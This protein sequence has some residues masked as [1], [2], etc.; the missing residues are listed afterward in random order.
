MRKSKRGTQAQQISNAPRSSSSAT[1]LEQCA[2]HG[3]RAHDHR[4]IDLQFAIL[5]VIRRIA[6]SGLSC[7]LHSRT[8]ENPVVTKL[9][10]VAAI[11]GALV[12]LTACSDSTTTSRGSVQVQLTDAPFPFSEV[13]RVD[14]HVL[15]IDA[16][17]ADATEA[18]AA[19]APATAPANENP[20]SGW[21]TI[22]T[23][24]QAFNMLSL[25]NGT[26]VNLGSA[27]SLPV[28]QYRG[29][30][31][32]IDT[33]LSSVTLVNG[34]VLRGTG[35][36]NIVWPSAGKTGIK[37]KLADPIAV[38]SNGGNASIVVIDF[39][40]ARSF[41]LRGSSISQNGLLFKPVIR[42]VA[43]DITGSISGTVR[44]GSATGAVVSG[45]TIEILKS[46]TVLTDTVSANVVATASTDAT[47]A[48]MA[49][50]LPPATYL[51]RASLGDRRVLSPAVTVA[52]SQA[53]T[54]QVLLLP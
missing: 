39:D 22:A 27:T 40:L 30:R 7:A 53:V 23:P 10:R 54:G 6:V 42:A 52:T 31:M 38:G 15:R 35:S 51:V 24:N 9:F 34:T 33:D 29:F 28:G 43:R 44:S 41:V 13:A 2:S 17:T 36:P 26:T 19:E 12:A 8:E 25:R 11:G 32:I 45:A 18:E 4:N 3:K 47:G 48:F 49:A 5:R 20:A 14:I 21:V 46:G 50:F 37:I 16:K 1:E